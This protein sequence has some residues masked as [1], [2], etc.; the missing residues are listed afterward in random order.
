MKI[1][2]TFLAKA[3]LRYFA[4]LLLLLFFSGKLY[5]QSTKVY[6]TSI[7]SNTYTTLPDNAVDGNLAT[8]ATVSASSG[9]ALNIGAYSGYVEL[10]YPTLLPANTTSYV[11]I[12]TQDNLLP[13]L[14]GGSLGAVVSNVLGAVLIGNQEFTVQAKNGTN[15]V[16]QGDSQD[17]G[18]FATERLRIITD[19]QGNF[20]VAI[21][22][23]L[24]YNRIRVR[25]RLG[26]V[27]GLFNTRTLNVFESFY[28]TGFDNCG[29]PSYT[30][31]SG[32]GLNLD[33]LN[34]GNIGVTNPGNAIDG[35][36]NTFS[37]LSLG[38][39]AVGASIEQTVYYNRLSE[40]SEEFNIRLKIDPSLLAL[41]LGNNIQIIASNGTNVVDSR[42]LNSLLNLDLLTLLQG[43]QTANIPFAPILPADRITVRYSSL[44]NV[45]LTQSL[46]LL[47]VVRV[48]KPP[49][50]S[51]PISQN[52]TICSGTTAS[53][54]ATTVAVNEVR[55]YSA[56]TGGTLLATLPSGTPYVTNPL[57][58]TT[59]FYAATIRTNCPEESRRVRVDVQVLTTPVAADIIIPS[60]LTA[61]QGNIT[62]NPSSAIGGATIKYY[63]DQNKTQEITTGYTGNPGVT[64]VKNP[65]TGALTITGLNATDSPYRYYISLT[66][67]GLCENVAN[68]LKEVTVNFSSQLSVLVTSPFAGCGAVNLRD[69]IT[70]FDSSNTY[71]F[72]DVANNPISAAAASNITTG[73][74]YFIQAQ[75]ASSAC[76]SGLVPVAVTINPR[77]TLTIPNAALVTQIGNTVTLNATSSAPVIW[78]NASGMALPSNVAG[79]FATAGT[80]TFTAIATLGPCSA[81]GSVTITVINPAECPPLT[82]KNFANTQRWGSNITGGVTNP[83]NAVDG[84]LQT[85]STIT[86]GLGIL[87]IGTTWQILE[88]NQTITAGTPVT[89]KLGSEYGGLTLAGGYSVVGT[90]RNGSG[91]PIDIGTLQNVSGSLLNLLPGQNNFEYTFVPSN[92]TGPQAYDGVRIVLSSLVSVAQNAKVYEAYYDVPATQIACG[93][94]A[95]DVLFGAVDL[96]IGVAIVLVGVDNAQNAIDN[97]PTSFATLASGAGILA[98]AEM[99]VVFRTPSVV[100]DSLKIS[101]SRPGTLITANVLAGLSIQPILNDALSGPAFENTSTLLNLQILGAG[102][103]AILTLVPTQSFD[104]VR[105]RF[106]GVVNVLD[107]LR[108]HD[109]RRI[110]NTKIIGSDDDNEITACQGQTISLQA[111]PVACTTFL[112]YDAATGG[113][114]IA[115]GNSY[116]IPSNLA[117]G[118][119]TY[120]IQPVRFGCQSLGRG[121]VTVNV[122][123]TAPT[124]SIAS[125]QINGGNDTTFCS[126][127]G[128][129]N[130]AAVLDATAVF[131]NPIFYWYSF[132]GTTQQL[133]PSQTGATLQLTGL[134][135]GTYTYFVGVGSD[136]YCQTAIG[137]RV[138]VTFT[139]YPPSL[140]TDIQAPNETVCLN[141]TAVIT[142]TSTLTNPQFTYYLTNATTQPITNGAVINGATYTI[143]ADGSLSITGLLQ[144]GSP[145]TYYIAVASDV[146]CLNT[147]GNLFAVTVTVG[148][149]ATPTTNNATQNFCQSTNPTVADLQ[150][151]E[152]G[153]I[154]YD[155]PTGGNLLVPTT[156]LIAGVYYAAQVDGDCESDIRL[157]ITVTIGNPDTPTA[158]NLTQNFCQIDN[159]TVA[160]IQVNETGVVF[161]DAPTG[162]NLIA[163][164]TPLVAGIYYASI[165]LGTCQ[166]DIRLAITV[167]ISDP[168]A[169][170]T[171]NATQTFCQGNNPT[172][173]DLDVNESNPVFYNVPTGGTPLVLT[174]ALQNGIYY[175]SLID[176]T[177]C[178]SIDR[179]QITVAITI[180]GPPTATE[181]TQTFCQDNNPTIADLVVNQTGVVFYDAPTGGNMYAPTFALVNGIYYASIQNGLCQSETR[182]AITVV[183]TDPGTPTTL[184]DTQTFCLVNNPTVANIQVN[185]TGVVFY[186]APTGGNVIVSTTPLANGIYYASIETG[187][188][189]SAVRLAITV[190][191]NNPLPPTTLDDT[192]EFC[193]SEN[194]TVADIQVNQP[195]VI[196]YPTPTGGTAYLSTDLLAN[197]I[198]YAVLVDAD[199]CESSVRLA[200]TVTTT[201]VGNPTTT[202]ISQNFC[203]AQNATVADIQVNQTGVVFYDAP[204]GGNIIPSTTPL[205]NG[206][207]YATLQNGICESDARLA[208]TVSIINPSVPTTLDDTQEF[209]LSS[210]PTVANLQVNEAGVIFYTSPAGGT[211]LAPTTPLSNGIYY[212]VI[213]TGNCESITR[214]A[215][216]VTLINLGIPTTGDTTQDFCQSNNP[217]V[218]NLQ[219][220]ETNVVFYNVPTG[221]TPLALN[222]PL[223]AGTYY[224]ALTNGTCESA[225]RLPIIVAFFPTGPVSITGGGDQACYSE[226]VTY[227]TVSGMTNYVWTVTSG[228]ITSGGQPTDNFVTVLWNSIGIG[229]VSVSFTNTNGC[230]GNN[231]ASRTIALVV[232]SDITITKTVSNPT[233]MI[234]D[235][236]VFTITVTNNGQSQFLDIIV[237]EQLPSGYQYVNSN[238]SVG[239]YSNVTGLWTIPVLSQGQSAT[240]TVTVKVLAT[241]DYM[242]TATVDMSDP[243]D[244]DTTNNT[245]SIAAEPLCLTVYNEF[246]PNSDGD[247]DLFRIDCIENYPN[248]ILNVYNRYGVEVYRKRAYQNDWDGTAN[249]N[250]PINQDNKLPTGTYYY[251]LDLGDGSKAKTGWIYIIR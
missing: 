27:L 18:E 119:Y 99:T 31:F 189:E 131:T 118:T 191:I 46:D 64:Y 108:V 230:A 188:C 132:D 90:K 133:I 81:S 65:T 141:S 135:A 198:Y 199:N 117:P 195:N 186:D 143:G 26:S 10:S 224:V 58:A 163:S 63:A 38:V 20:Y 244:S 110:A 147:A 181:T 239:N 114:V 236:V 73:G 39:L 53:L 246:S 55:W 171:D 169:P 111:G 84:N 83:G 7:V 97:S 146:T 76:S 221:G 156:P 200:I 194:P 15:V 94:D 248:N 50:I 35:N 150:V 41:G 47:E 104:K 235:N 187:L 17:E 202:S 209:C 75:N 112:W 233:P 172:V 134:A 105:I 12:Q 218:A 139:I 158:T 74:T 29:T 205:A 30:S 219:V 231:A 180:V 68:T 249:V 167:T 174:D 185:Q 72:F 56:A 208:I 22:P 170:T 4:P 212:A 217:T 23:N 96:G 11:K 6:A 215:I 148:N 3:V 16:L 125:I 9:I 130:L 34:L 227:S 210:N 45:Q 247:N 192:Q 91:T 36:P 92:N 211:A 2:F 89:I 160:S 229:T 127:T 162:G 142:P 124:A 175:V 220:N 151:N 240:L 153:V 102:D 67:N 145:Y 78:Y 123:P 116:T 213:R 243:V 42:T 193:L 184:D 238:A 122:R 60:V 51:S 152:T 157:A 107:I 226:T 5:S 245:A 237:R 48:P 113:N 159:P 136:E 149:P 24:P 214:L 1:N 37:Q 154:F 128:T 66:V 115:T 95:E 206:V 225:V 182:L 33:L 196:F 201:A 85:F 140:S 106:G 93:N 86:T 216:T 69:A 120:Y 165:Q 77:P 137:D 101:I 203:L 129:V 87:G 164:T 161:Y 103:E 197:G 190:T 80:Y 183:I 43:N 88:W 173:A 144:A 32:D 223:V 207:Y 242:N 14:L 100:G 82:Q 44:L 59:S 234:D 21:T 98:A 168:D 204:T 222:M 241:G 61:C 176:A 71:T 13:S 8:S 25:N 232:C 179:L 49:T 126:P 109:V 52:V 19:S 166:S 40:N 155:A 57:F 178:E 62:L 177:G 228:T 54:T 70:N 251:T 138:Q 250:S 28:I 121:E 79:P